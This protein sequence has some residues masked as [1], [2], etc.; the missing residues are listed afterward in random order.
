MSTQPH[1][2]IP[3]FTAGDRLK[4]AREAAGLDQGELA[5]TTGISRSTVSHLELDKAP[6]KRSYLQLWAM[7][8]GVPVEWLETGR[9]NPP[10][11]PGQEAGPDDEEAAARLRRLAERKR[12]TNGAPR[13]N[14]WYP[15]AA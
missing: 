5:E 4:K 12:P 15:E 3:A 2:R 6:L 7:A 1:G 11:P 13:D 14:H 10:P 9:D 8:T